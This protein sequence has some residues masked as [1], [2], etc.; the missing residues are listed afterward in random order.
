M[1]GIHVIVYDSETKKSRQITIGRTLG[2]IIPD[3]VEQVARY[4]E[5]KLSERYTQV[6]RLSDKRHRRR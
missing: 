6:T 2:S 4:L 1:K 5:T 3:S